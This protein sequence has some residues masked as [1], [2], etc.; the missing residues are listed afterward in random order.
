MAG[1]TSTTFYSRWRFKWQFYNQYIKSISGNNDTGGTVNITA[2]S[3]QFEQTS[4]INV[5]SPSN[6]LTIQN[7]GNILATFS[8]TNVLLGA[9][10]ATGITLSCTGHENIVCDQYGSSYFHQ[11]LSGAFAIGSAVTK[12]SNYTVSSNTD[13]IILVDTATA[14]TPVTITLF[15]PNSVSPYVGNMI[16]I[17]DLSGQAGTYNITIAVSSGGTIDGASTFTMNTN[18]QSITLYSNTVRSATNWMIFSSY[19]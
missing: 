4:S 5:A 7:N 3:L 17:K 12:T 13:T 10:T 19:S 14:A 8:A 16:T 2:S 15:N 11:G 1:R 18:Y 6:E 9:N